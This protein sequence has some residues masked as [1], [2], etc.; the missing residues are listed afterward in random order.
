[1][2]IGD[3][4]E[5]SES[6]MCGPSKMLRQTYTNYVIR[7]KLRRSIRP[8]IKKTTNDPERPLLLTIDTYIL[9]AHGVPVSNIDI[10]S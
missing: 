4:P 5:I 10:V 9:V 7:Y 1:M 3:H 6:Q 2:T 8:S